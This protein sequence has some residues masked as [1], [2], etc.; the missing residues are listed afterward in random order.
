[1]NKSDAIKFFGNQTKLAEALGITNSSISQW[2]EHV[3]PLRAFQIERLTH[4]KLKV[5]DAGLRHR[6]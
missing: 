6:R 5:V 3:P 2:G 1:M 4:G